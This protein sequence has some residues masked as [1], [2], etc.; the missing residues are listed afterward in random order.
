MKNLWSDSEAKKIVKSNSKKGISKELALR[1]YTS[2]LLG[3]NKKLVMHGGGNTSVKCKA[4]DYF[5]NSIDIL[6]IKGS[7]WDLGNIEA[8]G[9][10]A[11]R[12]KEL[13][14]LLKL[15]K[16]T[17]EE[18]VNAQRNNLLN[19][20][21]P[22]PSV[23]TLLHAIIPYRFVDHTHSDAILSIVDQHNSQEIIE[24][25]YGNNALFIPYIMPGFI[26]AKKAKMYLEKYPKCKLIIL[27]KHGIFTFGETAKSSYD[28]MINFV[29]KAER[30]IA[31]NKSQFVKQIKSFKNNAIFTIE[32]IAPIIRGILKNFEPS[33][34]QNNIILNFRSNKNILEYVNGEKLNIYSQKGTVT[35]DH[36]IRTK[37]LPMVIKLKDLSNLQS[38]RDYF[39]IE[40]KKYIKKYNSYFDSNNK[41]LGY[42][43]I[44]LDSLPRVILVPGL[45]L[46]SIGNNNKNAMIVGDLAE[47]NINVILDA[48]KIGN[49]KTISNSNAFDMEYWS[50]EQA[51]LK[52][53]ISKR[54]DGKVVVITGGCGAIGLSTASEFKKEGA[55]VVILDINSREIEDA[56]NK[57]NISGIS[58]DVTSVNSIKRSDWRR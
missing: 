25:I 15:D 42:N 2:R 28:A 40:L 48:E 35:P 3:N 20:S 30:F 10:P 7:G 9:L 16:L 41:R 39:L 11:V 33:D 5:G 29:T 47:T 14:N 19:S 8:E 43:K 44:K 51:K 58:C 36:V 18:M 57:L 17:D 49:Y 32:N 50:L 55:E 53:S 56:T 46:I 12:L 54:F 31:S 13:L 1:V 24:K 26:L 6:N 22:T 23:E 52:K 27:D 37:Q 45:G 21:S 38:F 34:Y 4:K